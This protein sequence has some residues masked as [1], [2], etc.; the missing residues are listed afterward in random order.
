MKAKLKPLTIWPLRR[1][2]RLLA[3]GMSGAMALAMSACS[4]DSDPVM[5]SPPNNFNTNQAVYY[6]NTNQPPVTPYVYAG[7]NNAPYLGGHGYYP[8]YGYPNYYWRPTPGSTVQL[9]SGGSSTY[10]AGSPSE[11]NES[12]ARGGFGASGEGE[13]G[14]GG[15]E[16]GHG[17]GE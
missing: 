10:Q 12:V 11:A 9:V 13:G 5:V 2:G 1:Q 6:D 8:L 7:A 3:F 17:G 16:G 14:H 15:G 4:R